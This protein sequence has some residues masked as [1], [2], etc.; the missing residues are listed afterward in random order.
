MD[1]PVPDLVGAAAAGLRPELRALLD[2]QAASGRPP[3]HQQS[4]AQA[5]RFHAADAPALNGEP[6]PVAAVADRTVPGP[7][8][9]L[10]LRVYT[11]EGEPPFPIVVFFH[12]GGWV[13]GT[14]DTYDPLCR[15]LAAAVP[16]VVVSVDY[17]LAP[18][19]RYPAAVED[20][21][22]A[23]FWA[24]RNAAALGGAQHRLAVA[25]DSA[26]GNLAAAVA[27]GAR[28]RGGPAISFQLL[29]YPALDAAGDTASWRAFA[30]GFHLTAAGMRWYWDH[31]L[32]G[33]DGGAPDASPLRAAYFGGL[34]PA[35]VLCA[36]HDVLLDEGEAYAARLRQ[37]GVAAEARRY[38]GTLHGFFRW[39]G[40]TDAADAA[41]Q[42]AATALRAAL[43]PPGG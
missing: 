20:A 35:L 13:V 28:D 40:V 27:L 3:L 31:Y 23:T 17:R 21:Y 14:L 19:H 6:V 18:E 37:A 9:A 39:R 11:P 42:D 7:G 12:G 25:G 41:L 10:P 15:A 22:A 29:V 1:T 32:G 26:G 36:D 4:V 24:S 33:A 16:A 2:R 43:A 34:P 5:R 30:D 8:G 38:A